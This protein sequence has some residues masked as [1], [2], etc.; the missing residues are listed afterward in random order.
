MLTGVGVVCALE[1]GGDL[2][3]FGA[4]G[5]GAVVQQRLAAAG[6]RVGLVGAVGGASQPLHDH[7]ALAF[8][9]V[10]APALEDAYPLSMGV[11]A[12]SQVRVLGVCVLG[13]HLALRFGHGS[14]STSE[15]AWHGERGR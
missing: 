12:G 4:H 2:E 14:A 8:G 9:A 3:Q 6:D 15:L 5:G 13:R 11:S 7:A 1:R 10:L